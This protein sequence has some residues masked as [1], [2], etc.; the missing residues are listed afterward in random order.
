MKTI[1]KFSIFTACIGC[2]CIVLLHAQAPLAKPQADKDYTQWVE[3]CLKDF[4][5]VKVGMTRSQVEG[6]LS[7]D[8][9]L[10]I[11]SPVRF[12]HPACGYFKI[13]V[14]FEFKRD[15]ADQNRA[16]IGEVDRVTKISKPY[17]ESPFFD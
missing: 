11:L 2:A 3:S 16:I 10:Q 6:K 4:E 9:G 12:T 13:D 5:S 15:A 7:K 8:G 1:L 17:I 14:E